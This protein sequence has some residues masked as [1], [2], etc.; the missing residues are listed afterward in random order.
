V[1]EG[2]VDGEREEGAKEGGS[3]RKKIGSEE[4]G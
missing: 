4:K 1:T 3:K 2:E